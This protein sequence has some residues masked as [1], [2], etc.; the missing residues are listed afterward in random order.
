MLGIQGSTAKASSLT[1]PAAADPRL[2]PFEGHRR[3]GHFVD[4]VSLPVLNPA[5]RI[6]RVIFVVVVT[7]GASCVDELAPSQC[8]PNCP[9]E[10]QCG[11]RSLEEC[12]AASCDFFTGALIA[13]DVDACLAS[14]VDCLEAAACACDGGCTRIDTCSDAEPDPTCVA[15]CD[16]L[17]EQEPTQ[18]YLENRCRIDANECGDLAACSSV[19]G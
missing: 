19:S 5:V 17:V 1:H 4:A 18:T 8:Q 16:T 14:A 11:F 15:T 6:L 7:V 9:I 10:A 2:G 13:P 3:C 12:E